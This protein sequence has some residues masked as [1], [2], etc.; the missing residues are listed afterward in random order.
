MLVT[1]LPD[2]SVSVKRGRRYHILHHRDNLDGI[3]MNQIADFEWEES[4]VG[5]YVGIEAY[6]WRETDQDLARQ[7]QM[8]W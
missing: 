7:R 2:S 8:V 1:G 3:R 5:T 6:F 4:N